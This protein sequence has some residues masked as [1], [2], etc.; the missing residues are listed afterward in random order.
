[1]SMLVMATEQD[2]RHTTHN[3]RALLARKM[4]C[5]RKNLAFGSLSA[6]L[7][8]YGV[9]LFQVPIFDFQ[10]ATLAAVVDAYL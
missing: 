2:R 10:G 9:K 7:F 6:Q 3:C 4:G 5:H 8:Q 1:M